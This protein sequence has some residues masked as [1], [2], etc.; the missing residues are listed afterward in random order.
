MKI[1][2]VTV[3]YN[4]EKTIRDTILSV[5]SQTYP[6]VE[7]I[8]VDFLYRH[9]LFPLFGDGRNLMQP[10]HA[11]DLG[12]AYYDVLENRERTFNRDY[13]LSGKEPISYRDLVKAV[14]DELG[15]SNILLKIP[16]TLS[17]LGARLYNAISKNPVITVE[18]VLRM[19][20][21]KVFDHEDAR[22][23]FGYAPLSFQEGIKEEVREYL[24]AIGQD[25]KI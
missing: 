6:D 22:R 9:K 25:R 4:S 23:D 2:I 5:L 15:R 20:E 14:S 12:N 21:D 17:I 8:L 3:S 13:N 16:L 1:S 24:E 11:R 10:V 18:Q 7:Y 19:Q